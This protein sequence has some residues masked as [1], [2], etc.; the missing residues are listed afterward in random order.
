MANMLELFERDIKWLKDNLDSAT[1]D[2]CDM[3]AEK[4]ANFV[5]QWGVGE[6]LARLKALKLVKSKRGLVEKQET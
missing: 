1:E 5:T 6:Y 4:V 2:E 3:F